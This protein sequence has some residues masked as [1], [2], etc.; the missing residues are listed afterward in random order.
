MNHH[1]L[2]ADILR[3]VVGGAIDLDRALDAGSDAA[4][5]IIDWS[6][7]TPVGRAFTAATLG[8]GPGFA[9]L[10]AFYGGTLINAG[11]QIAHQ[12][13]GVPMP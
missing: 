1:E 5:R 2:T 8:N 6:G 4:N 3:A 9:A 11:D 13:A 12:M 10:G 7:R